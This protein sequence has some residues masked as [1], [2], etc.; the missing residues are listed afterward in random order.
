MIR[1]K[2]KKSFHILQDIG[3]KHCRMPVWK[4]DKG[5]K[6]IATWTS[7]AS[8][9]KIFDYNVV[10]ECMTLERCWVK[11]NIHT[12]GIVDAHCNV[13]QGWTRGRTVQGLLAIRWSRENKNLSNSHC[14]VSD[15][16]PSL[17]QTKSS[18]APPPFEKKK[19]WIRA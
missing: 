6:K 5:K 1:L 16:K 10:I 15:F 14:K 9:F 7:M 4:D 19:I 17:L 11:S 18:L 13:W 8:Y 3:N 12:T 2:G